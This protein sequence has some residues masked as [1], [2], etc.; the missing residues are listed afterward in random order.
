MYNFGAMEKPPKV[1]IYTKTGDK[2]ETSLFG[3]KRIDKDHLRVETYGTIDELNAALGAAASFTKDKKVFDIIKKI[4]NDLF[5]IG[6]E[7]ANPQKVGK[8]T[9]R[10]F[11][12]GKS[13]IEE[14]ESIIDHLE[15]KLPPIREFILPSGTSEASLLHLARSVA[16]R[17]ERRVVSL[18]K[19]ERVNPDLLIYLNRLSDLLFVL[20]RHLNKQKG[21]KEARWEKE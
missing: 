1:R 10:L 7:L 19:K 15:E 5:N 8:D 9:K 2:G 3:G 20:S 13:K 21:L 16:R 18:S 12:L 14:L 17:A 4:Q 11:Q 6:A